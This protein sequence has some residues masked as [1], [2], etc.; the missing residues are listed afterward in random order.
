MAEYDYPEEAA[1][2]FEAPPIEFE[3]REGR[4][5][6]I[7]V[8]DE[9]RDFD[10]LCEMYDTFDPADRAQGIPPAR[11]ERVRSWLD[12]ILG[13]GQDVVA[14]H[15][16]RVVGHATLVPDGDVAT[17]LA[18]FVHQDYQGAGI[19]SRLI[20]ALLGYGART[21][22]EKVWLTVERWNHPAV[23][24]YESVGFESSS[25]ESFELEM[26]LRLD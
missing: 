5:I 11:E 4:S 18:I 10:A 15:G 3:D 2:P 13:E 19:G 1:G 21:G 17:E 23:T 12:V 25:V 7:R 24:L 20:R 26:T 14:A 8:Y 9:G 22:I 6:E 16:E